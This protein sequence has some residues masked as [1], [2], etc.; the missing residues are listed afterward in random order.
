MKQIKATP[1]QIKQVSAIVA[2]LPGT[3]VDVINATGFKRTYVYRQMYKLRSE[4]KVHIARQT[5][6]NSGGRA[7][8]WYAVGP[9]LAPPVIVKIPRVRKSRAKPPVVK[10]RP[11]AQRDALTAALFGP[12]VG[13][14]E[15]A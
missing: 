15:S 12:Y 11:P 3:V 13:Q 2:A 9:A 10:P 5:P 1:A 6:G 14:K 4:G 8:D 7:T